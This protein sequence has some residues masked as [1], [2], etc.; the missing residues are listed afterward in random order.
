MEDLELLAS[1]LYQ[2]IGEKDFE[3]VHFWLARNPR[4]FQEQ[5]HASYTLLKHALFLNSLPALQMFVKH[6][7]DVNAVGEGGCSLLD[8][9]NN[10][11]YAAFLMDHG[12]NIHH[13]DDHGNTSLIDAAAQGKYTLVESLIDRGVNL[14]AINQDGFTALSAAVSKGYLHIVRQLIN[15]GASLLIKTKNNETL[16]ELASRQRNKAV[17][18]YLKPFFDVIEERAV[19]DEATAS[20]EGS[21]HQ[22]QVAKNTDPLKSNL[23]RL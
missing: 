3:S 9:A 19:L 2:S 22:D 13:Q 1:L 10:R 12:I 17:V 6:G 15:S 18:A 8:F 20:K 16:L 4:L 21:T 14:D 11:D 23:R 5:P 7:A